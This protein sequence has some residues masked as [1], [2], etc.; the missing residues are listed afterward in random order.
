MNFTIEFIERSILIVFV[1]VLYG[2]A[3]NLVP[4]STSSTTSSP[5]TQQNSTAATL[6]RAQVSF[7]Y[8]DYYT[9]SSP[10]ASN[11]AGDVKNY[12]DP[13]TLTKFQPNVLNT[14][15]TIQPTFIKN[16][17][18]DITDSNADEST[19]LAY[20]CSY[21]SGSNA[22]P[23]SQCATFDYGAIGGISSALGG[24]LLLLGGL[25]SAN[26]ADIQNTNSHGFTVGCGMM[27]SNYNQCINTSP[28]VSSAYALGVNSLSAAAAGTS[29]SPGLNSATGPISTWVNLASNSTYT[30]PSGSSGASLVYNA[31]L[32]RLLFFGGSIPVSTLGSTS[33]GT[34][35]YDTWIYD[36]RTQ[37]WIQ[38]STN[39]VINSNLLS[40]ADNDTSTSPATLR[41]LAKEEQGRALFGYVA[42]SGMSISQLS[43]SGAGLGL[44]SGTG[45]DTTDRIMIVGGLGPCYNNLCSDTHK[46]NPTYSPEYFDTHVPS[47]NIATPSTTPPRPTQWID[48][49]SD[50]LASNSNT[51]SL[52]T[53][54]TWPP[55]TPTP[56]PSPTP[57][58]TPSA[59]P[60]YPVAL[61]FG[62]VALNNNFP[63]SA[64]T[65]ASNLAQPTY[66]AVN[67]PGAGYL[68]VAG[69]FYGNAA[70][71]ANFN[72][73]SGIC[74]SIQQCGG[75]QFFLKWLG[76]GNNANE[77]S[78]SN[79]SFAT[80]FIDILNNQI[81][82]TE[83]TPGEWVSVNQ[84]NDQTPWFGGG[85]M[86]KG[87]NIPTGTVPTPTPTPYPSPTSTIDPSALNQVVYFG[88]ADCRNYMTDSTLCPNWPSPGNVG[89]Y[90]IFGIDPAYT[91]SSGMPSP[92]PPTPMTSSV[93]TT[94]TMGGTVPINAGMA[95]ARG[96]DPNGNP[97]I[98]AWAGMKA[99]T[100]IDNSGHIY[101][102]YNNNGV[103]TWASVSSTT[104]PAGVANGAMVF[105]HV[106]GKFYLFGGYNPTT[107]TNGDTWELSVS[108]AN[109]GV[110]TTASCIFSWT[111][112]N[113]THGLTCY[114]NC[115]PARRSHRMVEAN[116]NYFNAPFE[117]TCTA[118]TTPC[119]FGIFMEGGTS[120]GTFPLFSD[121]WMF[122]P[123]ANGGAG[124][125]QLAGDFPPRVLASMANVDYQ[126]INSS[127]PVHRAILFGGE[128]GMQDPVMAT[129]YN[130]TSYF[131]PPTLGDTWMYDYSNSS[132]NLV[133]LYG[134]RYQDGTTLTSLSEIEARASSLESDTSTQIFSPP[135]T[136]GAIMVTRTLSK[137]NHLSTDAAKSLLIPE[138]FL[139]GG[140]TKE[141]HY[142]LL[143]SVYKFCAGSTGE[144]P[145]PNSLNGTVVPGPDDAS[146]DAYDPTSNPNSP[147][148]I[149]AYTG[150]WLVKKPNGKAGLD[151]TQVASY[152][153]AGAYD[154]THDLIIL[155]GGLQPA[156]NYSNEAVTDTS[157]KMINNI[158]PAA[159]TP[160][161][162]EY[163][164]PSAVELGSN[165]A[166]FNGTWSAVPSC[167]ESPQLPTGR[168]AH[169][170][171]YDPHNQN[172]IMVG[173]LDINGNP[174]IQ[175]QTY[176]DG[177]IYTIPEIWTATRI[178][179]AQPNG[180]PAI[181]N[182]PFPCYYWSQITLFGN[183]IDIP[184]QTPPYSGLANAASVLIPSTG[185]NTGFY[186][187]FDNVC[188]NTGPIASADPTVSKLLSGG[189]YFDI[190]RTQLG[191]NENL[192][193][194]LTF[195]PLGIKNTE[196]NLASLSTTEQAVFRIHLIKTNEATAV[197]QQRLQPRDL[198]YSSTDQYPEIAQ[199]ITVLTPPVGQIRQEQVY[200]PLSFNSTIDRIRI[201]RY[202]GNAILINASLYR[203]GQH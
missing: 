143:N 60:T 164:P 187:T 195:I 87:I 170:L 79:F 70:S 30:G 95:A 98:V 190:D 118:A 138:V 122:D 184:A 36:L 19:N 181:A 80:N 89:K 33:F 186:T 130:G 139:F 152:M 42:A 192:I 175:T 140:R 78:A 200:I 155:Y 134:H 14:A 92:T 124:H 132:W 119:S 84:A 112:L 41:Q 68:A 147:S 159:S 193:L 136:S 62:M 6:T 25:H 178:D 182:G 27:G 15:T 83:N 198:L 115:P 202:S 171:A 39:A 74:T 7:N 189:A 45:V 94:V 111:P 73:P 180:Q 149:S 125:W 76:A 169:S 197:L 133:S 135:P 183:S 82:G 141:G 191:S 131:V 51:A 46:F 157:N 40:I 99:P 88:G 102:L 3:Q 117:P 50:Q 52:Y 148:P 146:C 47:N 137:A 59:S 163:T 29:L 153:G 113:P 20:S 160:T 34:T 194:N 90:W 162:L 48:S 150:R 173:G 100:Q 64:G 31:I 11:C 101:Y 4:S 116:Y 65:G 103:P 168:Y 114:P 199:N 26:Y 179:S 53:P 145:Y 91:F 61:S 10:N 108:G 129:G 72:L 66:P 24:S 158:S 49:Y 201:E 81:L 128:T 16:V 22:P 32:Q 2:C 161:L 71:S 154:S 63:S 142:N 144:K 96:T 67:T 196:P 56:S 35:T 17:S 8:L 121:R 166:P 57:T 69:G 13:L 9:L 93:P 177:T 167:A 203:L 28:N 54:N 43:T 23:V 105:S 12:Y 97:I 85:V 44:V 58:P 38:I 188:A 165:T 172:L 174:L 120:T 104:P 123:T 127:T 55:P 21:G 106:T 176:K 110:A 151:T 37:T 156:S 109:C 18:V 5:L 107:G 1:S 75:M 77:K 126:P 86:L 185:Y